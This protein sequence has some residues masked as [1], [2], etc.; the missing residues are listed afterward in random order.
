MTEITGQSS[1]L[2][3]AKADTKVH[4]RV[5]A[6]DAL[7]GFDMFWILGAASLLR[8]L[9]HVNK[10]E[11][12][13]TLSRQL[14]H[15]N[16]EGCHFYDIIFPLFVFLMGASTVGSLRNTVAREGRSAA[17]RRVLLRA[18][19]LYLLGLVYY[20]GLSHDGGPE[21]FRYMGVLQRIAICYLA[22]GVLFLNFR[23]RGLLVSCAGLLIGYWIL[24]TFVPVS[25]HGA[26][27]YEEGKNLANYLDQ[28]Y[29]PGY[30]LDGN[31]NWDPEGLLSTLPAIATGLLGIFAGL[32]LFHADLSQR[33]KFGRLVMMGAVCLLVGWLWGLQFPVIKKLW[34]S[35]FVLLT[36]GWSYL[37]LA[38][39]YLVID[40]CNIRTWAQPFVWIGMNPIAIYM[41]ANLVGFS[42]LVRRVV[43]QDMVDAINPWGNL[44]VA[45]LS[46]LVAVGICYV[47]HRKRIYIRV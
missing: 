10:T 40:I 44:L 38:I 8:G 16:W 46:L 11:F 12:V 18:I 6:I 24:M 30:K 32:I 23:F 15:V 20:G 21:M 1:A 9:R 13:S 42:R 7:R 2:P 3:G 28:H 17:Y 34:T 31:G 41:L 33:Q 29:L 35:S 22:G 47:L 37:L 14:S 26:G 45:L 4:P 5:V 19:I 39:F 36:A 43:H 25:E 27:N